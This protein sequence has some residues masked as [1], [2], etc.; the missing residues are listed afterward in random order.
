M[1]L[2]NRVRKL[3]QAQVTTEDKDARFRELCLQK[4][5]DLEARLAAQDEEERP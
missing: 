2:E 1:S 5:R 3:E 4:A